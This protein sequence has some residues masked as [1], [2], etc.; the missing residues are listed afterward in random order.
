[1]IEGSH[2]LG[3]IDH[4]TT[5]TQ[6]E[7]E[8]NRMTEILKTHTVV[9]PDLN[10]GDSIW[11]HCNTLHGSGPNTSENTRWA[12][13]YSYNSKKNS[14]YK[15]H[16]CPQYEPLDRWHDDSVLKLSDVPVTPGDG[17][18]FMSHKLDQHPGRRQTFEMP[19]TKKFP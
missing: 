6:F 4:V 7:A 1:L 12:M 17:T 5:G 8:P 3:R 15:A 13:L 11:F 18:V 14:P 9:Q 16:H 10:P 2:K 19:Q